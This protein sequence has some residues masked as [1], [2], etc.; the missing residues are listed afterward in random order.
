MYGSLAFPWY[1]Q[2]L[3]RCLLQGFH[4]LSE[5]KE[6]MARKNPLVPLLST[7]I[8]V[9]CHYEVYAILEILMNLLDPRHPPLKHHIESISTYFWMQAHAVSCL[10]LLTSYKHRFRWW[11]IL[12][13]EISTCS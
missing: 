5:E 4:F 12:S 8:I 6:T 2:I 11:I 9:Q 3:Q 13:W 10:H 1:P 7:G